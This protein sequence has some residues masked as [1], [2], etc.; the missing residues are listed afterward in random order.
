MRPDPRVGPGA[1]PQASWRVLAA[2]VMLAACGA[3]PTPV[4][5]T[6]TQAPV[7]SRTP[8]P[9]LTPTPLPLVALGEAQVVD[10]GG[11][12][13]RPPV[14]YDIDLHPGHVGVADASGQ[15]IMSL[16]GDTTNPRGLSAQEIADTFLA[17]MF[18]A[19]G[20]AYTPVTTRTVV[21]SGVAGLAYDLSGTYSGAPVRGRAVIV[22]PN[23]QHYL[24]GLGLANLTRDPQ[25][26]ASQ[27]S[28]LFDALI[29]TI[30]FSAAVAPP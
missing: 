16:T 20:G 28:R 17:G 27:G 26:W 13:F 5:P 23:A 15:I 30:V 2:A 18:E 12:S 24:F 4:P 19:A 9:T 3:P 6:A 14:G 1:A 25:R 11:F 29:E 21:I 10:G 22:M 8:N 7:A